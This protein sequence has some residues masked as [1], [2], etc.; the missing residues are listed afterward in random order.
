MSQLIIF[1]IGMVVGAVLVLNGTRQNQSL[2]DKE[3][4][5]NVVERQQQEKA[6]NL[7]RVLKMFEGGAE[8]TNDD[9]EH[10]LGVSNATA[11]RY[12]DELEKDGQ[13]TQHGTTGKGVFYTK[14]KTK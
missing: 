8:V 7:R 5:L 11:E 2:Q 14:N 12:L 1:L 10:A 3:E 6:E 13:I 4:V 9:V